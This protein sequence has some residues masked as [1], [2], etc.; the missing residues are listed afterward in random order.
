MDVKKNEQIVSKKK[1]RT[2]P[3]FRSLLNPAIRRIVRLN[4]TV[5]AGGKTPPPHREAQ[6]EL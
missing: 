4:S 3:P 2:M 1:R 5:L 6:A